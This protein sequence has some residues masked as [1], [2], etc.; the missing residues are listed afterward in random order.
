MPIIP[1]LN[2]I[3]IHI[4][5]T[6]GSSINEYFQLARMR[7]QNSVLGNFLCERKLPGAVKGEYGKN[8]VHT[9]VDLRPY[10][11]KGDFIRIGPLLYQVH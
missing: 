2:L 9:S 6:G 3:F 5:K 1:N 8:F 7:E 11:S 4:P 10:I